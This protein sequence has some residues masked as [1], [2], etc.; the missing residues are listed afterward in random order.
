MLYHHYSE[1][2]KLPLK[3]QKQLCEQHERSK[4]H[5]VLLKDDCIRLKMDSTKYDIVF[6]DSKTPVS[7]RKRL[8]FY[9]ANM[10]SGKPNGTTTTGSWL[11]FVVERQCLSAIAFP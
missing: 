9:K 3:Q 10:C 2:I 5:Q 1:K 11:V 8:L 4:E 6:C 7:M